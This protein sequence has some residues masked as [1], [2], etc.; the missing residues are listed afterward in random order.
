MVVRSLRTWL[1]LAVL[2][3]AAAPVAAKDAAGIPARAR[4]KQRIQTPRVSSV[5]SATHAQLT[6]TAFAAGSLLRIAGIGF[7]A[8]TDTQVVLKAAGVDDGVT[9]AVVSWKDD[10]ILLQLP[11]LT[12]LG[13]DS[14]TAAAL[15]KEVSAE[16]PVLSMSASIELVRAQVRLVEPIALRVVL[17]AL[18]F[19]GDKVSRAQDANDLDP[20]VH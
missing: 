11:S 8:A 19:D 12:E 9:L 10:E 2:C 15:A 18:D 3:S 13:I 1:M 4:G 17:A 14:T 6:Q 20:Q 7:G 5:V 16:R